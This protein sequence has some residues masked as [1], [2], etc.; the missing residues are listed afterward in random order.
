[1]G[2]PCDAKGMEATYRGYAQSNGTLCGHVS[3]M[4]FHRRRIR[5][6]IRVKKP[7]I[8]EHQLHPIRD[9]I[10]IFLIHLP[11][12]VEIVGTTLRQAFPDL[13]S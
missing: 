13:R 5:D 2:G 11:L 10:R 4:P 3:A 6:I 12:F 8:L 7:G 1:M 9:P